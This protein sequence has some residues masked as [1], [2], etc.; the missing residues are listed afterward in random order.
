MFYRHIFSL[1]TLKPL[2]YV[3]VRI[4]TTVSNGFNAYVYTFA[5]NSDDNGRTNPENACFC[6]NKDNCLPDGLL[7][8][9][10]CYYGFPIALSY[11]HFY[12]GDP[13]M[14]ENVEGSYPDKKKHE[15]YFVVEPVS[16]IC[17]LDFKYFIYGCFLF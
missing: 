4:N 8:V 12:N 15:S 1:A 5:N 2:F 13:W 10:G 9:H 11:P 16:V 3:Q 14:V 17:F 7:D 6:N